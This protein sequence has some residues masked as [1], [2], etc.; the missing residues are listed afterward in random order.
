MK[1]SRI[2]L[3]VL[4]PVAIFCCWLSVISWKQSQQSHIYVANVPAISYRSAIGLNA[5]VQT[6]ILSDPNF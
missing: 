2:I 5:A 6:G 4:S 1:P 3:A